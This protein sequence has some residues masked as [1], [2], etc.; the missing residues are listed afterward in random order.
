MPCLLKTRS[1]IALRERVELIFQRKEAQSQGLLLDN[2]SQVIKV[3]L[4]FRGGTA[5]A[6]ILSSSFDERTREAFE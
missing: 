1:V 2:H 5:D 6:T 4:S 3:C